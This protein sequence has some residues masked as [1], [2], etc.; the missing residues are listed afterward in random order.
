MMTLLCVLPS[1]VLLA[2]GILIASVSSRDTLHAAGGA[3]VGAVGALGLEATSSSWVPLEWL[4]WPLLACAMLVL[5]LVLVPHRSPQLQRWSV[6]DR[7]AL[8]E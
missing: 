6:T 3:V 5:W 7:G 8:G 1:L 4:V 2:G